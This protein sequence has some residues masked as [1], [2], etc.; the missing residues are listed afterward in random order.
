MP[1]V[2][3]TCL[4]DSH[5]RLN[6][7]ME[8]FAGYSMPIVYTSIPEEHK[9]VREK[10]GMFDVSHMGEIW[11]KGKDALA[12]VDH[13]FCNEITSKPVGKVVYGMFLYPNGTIVDDL[14]VYKQGDT[15]CLLVV[16]ASNIA[17]DYAWLVDATEG[18]DVTL[19]NVSEEVA[20]IALQGP[21]A[22][23]VMKTVFEMDFSTLEFFTFMHLSIYGVDLIVSRTGYTGEDGFEIYGPEGAIT[24][25]WELFLHQGV[26]PC[27]LGARDTLRFEAALPLYGHE[28]SDSITPLEAGFKMFVRM[29]KPDF[30]GKKQLE[31]DLEAGLTRKVVGYELI[32]MAIPRQGYPLFAG[33]REIG[34]ITT[35]YLSITLGKP[36]AMALVDI[37][38]A[39]MG[40][41]L[42]VQIRNK[43]FR[44][45]VRDKK[46]L[47]KNYK[48]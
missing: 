25:I 30:V 29:D 43:R 36:I 17:K 7:R 40:S 4:Y 3:K 15:E 28:I 21:L 47:A 26:L 9:A 13:V 6:A 44:G 20:E 45:I 34:K 22:E 48:K 38:H 1:E 11:V 18:F 42:E 35:G 39:K 32:D 37:D 24:E 33:D 46:F 12:F 5:V 23:N 16:N 31:R 41:E 2:K 14:L 19:T 10:V 8:E 27:G